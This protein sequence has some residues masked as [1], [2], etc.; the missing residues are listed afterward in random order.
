MRLYFWAHSC[1][2]NRWTRRK[3][4]IFICWI[5]QFILPA[6][7]YTTQYRTISR[8]HFDEVDADGSVLVC[9]LTTAFCALLKF[10]FVV[11]ARARISDS[12]DRFTFFVTICF[13][14]WLSACF[15]FLA[16]IGASKKTRINCYWDRVSMKGYDESLQILL[17][18]SLRECL[19][20]GF[21]LL[22]RRWFRF[23][24]SLSHDCWSDENHKIIVVPLWSHVDLFWFVHATNTT[25]LTVWFC[26]SFIAHRC[27]S[28]YSD[29]VRYSFVW[30][31]GA[32]SHIINVEHS[33]SNRKSELNSW[34]GWVWILKH[35][36]VH[37][38]EIY[39]RNDDDDEDEMNGLCYITLI[40]LHIPINALFLAYEILYRIVTTDEDKS[41]H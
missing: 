40:Y 7:H 26:H 27:S 14:F 10:A 23:F 2:S 1:N 29:S 37:F 38:Q 25:I 4:T 22:I 30:L 41:F 39:W 16:W 24:V 13:S 12:A 31:D 36:N 21:L 9:I 8:S 6:F 15:A 11:L 32:S 5:C 19:A 33:K 20:F 18:C 35:W 28:I 17:T 3:K 34:V